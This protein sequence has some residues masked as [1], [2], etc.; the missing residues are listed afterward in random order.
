M[1]L[2]EF[3]RV[4]RDQLP[5]DGVVVTDS[6]L[7]QVAT[8]KWYEV[9]APR[10]LIL[11]SD[12][13][14]MGFG[15]PAAIGASLAMSKRKVVAIVGDGGMAMSGLELA[16]AV[17][18]GI[19]L[20]VVVFNDGH[21]GQIR[22]QQL[23]DYGQAHGTE[24]AAIDFRLLAEAVGASYL[25]IDGSNLGHLAEALANPGVTVVDLLLE[26][27]PGLKRTR[28]KSLIKAATRNAVPSSLWQ[29]L[30]RVLRRG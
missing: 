13:Q 3:F 9:R 22:L 18:E 8:R 12:F 14:S 26:D 16:S 7:H 19:D 21:L 27:S 24:L 5:D 30:K 15:I 20:T 28:A 17:R 29:V 10:G 1:G 25:A 4:L 2:Q 6:G 11:P 23:T